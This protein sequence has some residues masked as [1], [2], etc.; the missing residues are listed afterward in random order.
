LPEGTPTKKILTFQNEGKS[1]TEIIQSLQAEGYSFQ[2]ISEGL[3]QAVAKTAVETSPPASTQQQ[4]QPTTT[5]V[6]PSTPTQPTTQ[7]QQRGMQPSVLY[8]EEPAKQIITQ[9][10]PEEIEQLVP[11]PSQNTQNSPNIQ[12]TQ[13][14]QPSQ[15]APSFSQPY[16]PGTWPQ[17]QPS[18]TPSVFGS[19]T[20]DIEEIAEAIIN[21]KWQKAMEGFGDISLFKEKTSTDIE[22]VKQEIL[23]LENRFDNL[24]AS[25]MG[26][27]KEYDETVSGVGVELKALEKVMRNIIGPLTKNVKDLEKVSERLGK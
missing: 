22:S 2:Q 3:N 5:T 19:T 9:Q 1:N 8:T 18:F 7:T 23:R 25:L 24:Q 20:E 10:R 26:K 15:I 16:Q 13:Q 21:E 11:A 17:Q 12:K 4:S 14:Q 6:Q 27:V